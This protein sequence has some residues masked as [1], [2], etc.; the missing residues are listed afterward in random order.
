MGKK[1]NVVMDAS[2]EEKLTTRS[3]NTNKYSSAFD[4]PE[5]FAMMAE[6]EGKNDSAQAE[7]EVTEDQPKKKAVKRAKKT[8]SKK[9]KSLK[10][11]V[12]PQ[13]E[14][15]VTEAVETVLNLSKEK[16]DA[17]I[18]LNLQTKKDGLGGTFTLPHGT[19]KDKKIVI[20][21]ED[22]LKDIS[23]GKFE[24]DV[25]V[26]KPE[27][28]PKL[29]KF[30]KFLG[31]RGLMP[32]PKNGTIS[33]DPEKAAKKLGGNTVAYKTEKKAPLVHLLVGKRSFGEKKLT[34]NILAVFNEI[35]PKQVTRASLA[36]SMGPGVKIKLD[37]VAQ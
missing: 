17:S 30:A 4:L 2:Q 15:S 18:E 31:P 7:T 28:M 34:E 3:S 33:P 21:S 5:E 29:A 20:F 16:F 13:K 24:F 37:S 36:S 32:N 12:D 26:A 1:R 9:F 19:G 14:Y 22:L 25:L 23:A 35:N 6:L 10:G 27:D 8:R 11:K